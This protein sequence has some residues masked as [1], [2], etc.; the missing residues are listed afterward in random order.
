M[1]SP[2][3]LS[4]SQ[5]AAYAANAGFT[6][7]ALQNAVAIALAESGGHTA[8]IGDTNLTPGGSVGLWQINLAAHPEYASV[9]LLDPQQNANAAFDIYQAAGERFTPWTTFKTGVYAAS[10]PAASATPASSADSSGFV[11]LSGSGDAS[12]ISSLGLDPNVL[13]IGGVVGALAILWWATD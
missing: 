13:I 11:D 8:V 7:A 6:G 9:N 4:A 3:P 10:L 1:P 5:I 12:G 2:T